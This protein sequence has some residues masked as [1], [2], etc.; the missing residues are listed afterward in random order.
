MRSFFVAMVLLAAS[1]SGGCSLVAP[2]YTASLENVQKLKDAGDFKAKVGAFTS[3][4]SAGNANP[5]SMRGSK[6]ASPY[7]GTYSDY[8]AEAV[9]QE[10]SLAGRL[11]PEADLEVSGVL[12]KND[13]NIG[14]FSTGYGDMGARFVLKRAGQIRY[15][16]VKTVHT[17]WD[18]SFVGAIAIPRGQ[19]EYPRLVQ[20]LLADLYAD[21]SFMEALK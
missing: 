13:I 1:L 14:G 4:P 16:S 8:L 11:A 18:S 7:G 20:R 5:I 6:L 21:P 3:E 19:Q 12:I 2:K 9:K 17:G 15:Y 10:L